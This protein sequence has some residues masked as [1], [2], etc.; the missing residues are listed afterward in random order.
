VAKEVSCEISISLDAREKG[1]R[2]VTN[3]EAKIVEE[4]EA[5]LR[6]L[7]E[8][9]RRILGKFFHQG[10]RR[11]SPEA[12]NVAQARDRDRDSRMPLVLSWKSIDGFDMNHFE[13]VAKPQRPAGVFRR[14]R[15]GRRHFRR[16]AGHVRRGVGP[17]RPKRA[18]PDLMESPRAL[19]ALR[20]RMKGGGGPSL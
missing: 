20:G 5:S 10:G 19:R 4:L 9:E 13:H 7:E 18:R 17:E 3:E 2:E 6:E 12:D 14:R 8:Q 1:P 16:P 15:A 11:S